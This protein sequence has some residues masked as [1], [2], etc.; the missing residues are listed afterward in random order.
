[1]PVAGRATTIPEA[2]LAAADDGISGAACERIRVP[3]IVNA[4]RRALLVG[5]DRCARAVDD[6]DAVLRLR[7][8]HHAQ[9]HRRIHQVGE[10]HHLL[11]VDPLACNRNADVRLVLMVGGNHLDRAPEHLAAEIVDRHLDR[12]HRP[13]TGDVGKQAGHVGEH[14]DPHR[15]GIRRLLLGRCAADTQARDA[16]P[17]T[18]CD[19]RQSLHHGSAVNVL[20]GPSN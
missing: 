11:L 7:K 16:E 3:R 8:L 10:H 9:R 5:D 15:R 17:R 19:G 18:K 12:H 2:L 13:G 20:H 14:P 4:V 1:M 6:R